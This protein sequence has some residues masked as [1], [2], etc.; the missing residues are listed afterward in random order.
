M[1]DL[2]SHTYDDDF[3]KYRLGGPYHW[4]WYLTDFDSYRAFVTKIIAELPHDGSLLDIGCGDGLM[5]FACWRH[6]LSVHGI[7]NNE[8]AIDLANMVCADA[9]A[10]THDAAFLSAG[11]VIADS[12]RMPPGGCAIDPPTFACR[13]AFD[14]HTSDGADY[15]LCIEVI[16]HVPEPDRLLAQIHSLIRNYAIITTPDGTDTTPG[17]YDHQIWTPDGFHKFLDGYRFEPL[18][19]RA[20]TI[21]V[22]LFKN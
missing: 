1:S 21:A 3:R 14:L 12:L 20:G 10:G 7:D 2:S 9:A 15:A 22:K 18:D 5:S 11:G 13:S 8:L 16:E 6:G 17:P 19:L 4:K